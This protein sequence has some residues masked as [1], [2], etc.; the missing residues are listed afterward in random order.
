MN[1]SGIE[2]GSGPLSQVA[3]ALSSASKSS[4]NVQRQEDKEENSKSPLQ[5]GP[6]DQQGVQVEISRA[7]KALSESQLSTQQGSQQETPSPLDKG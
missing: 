6:A 7:A 1:V 2:Q 5:T 3:N 4:T